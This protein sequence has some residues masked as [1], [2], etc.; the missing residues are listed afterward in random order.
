MFR[1]FDITLSMS[2]IPAFMLVTCRSVEIESGSKALLHR[3]NR[4]PEGEAAAAVA[5]VE[6]DAAFA[7]FEQIGHYLAV[8]VEHGDGGQVH[9][10]VDIAGPQLLITS[11]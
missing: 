10:R 6:N 11:S 3:R 7:R 9:V 1:N 4:L 2:F 5:H 8:V